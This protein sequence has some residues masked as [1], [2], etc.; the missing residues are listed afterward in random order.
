MHISP[1]SQTSS[2][3]WGSSR[4]ALST[5]YRVEAETARAL[6]AGIV[7]GV[8]VQDTKNHGV[9]LWVGKGLPPSEAEMGF[10][11]S[12]LKYRQSLAVGLS[13]TSLSETELRLAGLQYTGKRERET[14]PYIQAVK[15]R[16]AATQFS[17]REAAAS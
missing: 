11:S 3:Y 15:Y 17:E 7:K 9:V 16:W 12:S 1:T 13:V 8:V 10:L 6:F 5:A 2:S 4:E 14:R